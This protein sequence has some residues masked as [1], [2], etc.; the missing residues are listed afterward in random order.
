KLKSK[1]K[2]GQE[3]KEEYEQEEERRAR[4]SSSHKE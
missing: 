2:L 3:S 1:A 4:I